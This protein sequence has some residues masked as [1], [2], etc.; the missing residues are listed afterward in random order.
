MEQDYIYY[1]KGVTSTFLDHPH[2]YIHFCMESALL[3]SKKV[4]WLNGR[5]VPVDV[6]NE[7]IRR[8]EQE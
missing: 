1:L 3:W 7:S 4:R 8:K 5:P 6:F 2:T